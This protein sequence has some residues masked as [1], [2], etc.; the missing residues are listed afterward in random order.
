MCTKAVGLA[1]AQL[2]NGDE[3]KHSIREAFANVPCPAAEAIGNEDCCD[4]CRRLVAAFKNVTWQRAPTDLIDANCDK[5]PLFQPAAFH[6]FLPAFLIRAIDGPDSDVWTFTFYAVSGKPN[7]WLEKRV[8]LLTAAQ[9]ECIIS[10]LEF[11]QR[12]FDQYERWLESEK[13]MEKRF[14]YWRQELRKA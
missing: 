9:I 2:V 3:L 14:D 1:L 12:Q 10:Y 7:D 6:H 13:V 5:L 8:E 11:T 4:E